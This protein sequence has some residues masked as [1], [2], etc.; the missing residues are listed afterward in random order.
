VTF[1]L[2]CNQRFHFLRFPTICGGE[3]KKRKVEEPNETANA[4]REEL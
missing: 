2:N 4:S 3:A 1:D